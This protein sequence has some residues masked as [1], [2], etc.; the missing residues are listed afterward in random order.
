MPVQPP[1]FV[2]DAAA[3][4][5]HCVDGGA[6]RAQPLVHDPAEGQHLVGT[7]AG[8]PCL[9]GGRHQLR[10]NFFV[11]SCFQNHAPI[12]LVFLG[13][14]PEHLMVA[15][16]AITVGRKP[17]IRKVD[18]ALVLVRDARLDLGVEREDNL[19]ELSFCAIE[20]A[21]ARRGTTSC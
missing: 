20:A 9:V 13:H 17:L 18:A 16:D 21:R 2:G 12:Q 15:L 10:H 11:P 8:A 14:G 19:A 4:I 1:H 7:Q 5:I 6:A 3:N